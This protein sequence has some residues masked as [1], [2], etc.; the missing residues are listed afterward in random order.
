MGLGQHASPPLRSPGA[1]YSITIAIIPEPQDATRKGP[2]LSPV[3]FLADLLRTIHHAGNTVHGKQR[4]SQI[5]IDT[6]AE[7]TYQ[8]PSR[9]NEMGTHHT[10][11]TN[12]GERWA[13]GMA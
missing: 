5:G 6:N 13:A 11:G 10:A 2:S 4:I 8:T 7:R 12:Q 9:F 1:C 3:G